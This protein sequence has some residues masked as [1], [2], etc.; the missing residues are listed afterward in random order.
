MTDAAGTGDEAALQSAVKDLPRRRFFSDMPDKGLFALAAI[1]GFVG[2]CL[3]KLDGQSAIAVSVM[4]VAAML[5]YGV[6]AYHMPLVQMRLDRLGDNFYY[7]G[8]IYTLASLS[9]ALLQLRGSVEVQPLLGGFGIA[10]VTT[11]VGIS[12]RVLLLQ[13]RSDLDDVENRTRR[14]LSATSAH[15]RGQM[16]QSIVDFGTFRTTLLQVLS[17]TQESYAKLQRQQIEDAGQLTKATT[18]Q[19]ARTLEANEQHARALSAAMHLIAR[20]ADEATQKLASMQLPSE[21][22]ES[23]L[24]AFAIKLEGLLTRLA[25]TIEDVAQRAVPRR[26]WWRFGR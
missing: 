26:R 11:I 14:E 19:I 15:L 13:L 5:T 18:A 7:L 1:G 2:I 23:D 12:G 4:A 3:L 6:I 22:L 9:A 10:L 24:S 17:E 20:S 8:F 25:Q 21:R 16:G